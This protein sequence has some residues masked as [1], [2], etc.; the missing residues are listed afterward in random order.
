MAKKYGLAGAVLAFF[1]APQIVLAPKMP[2]YLPKERIAVESFLEKYL[3]GS[4]EKFEEIKKE[5]GKRLEEERRKADD[6]AN[7]RTSDFNEDSEEL[8]LARMILGEGE[9]CTKLEKIKI[10][11]TAINRKNLGYEKTLKEVILAPYQYSCFNSEMYSS[12]FLKNPLHRNEQE[13]LASLQ[14]ARDVLAGKYPDPT[15]GAVSYYNP[16]AI[17][18]PNWAK[19]MKKIATDKGD[20]HFFFK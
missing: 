5:Y 14:I 20:Y 16:R 17:K 19:T 13:F 11:W 1:L 15:K 2:F 8:L 10:A 18:Q 9:S 6:L 12:T 4:K 3:K 7:Y